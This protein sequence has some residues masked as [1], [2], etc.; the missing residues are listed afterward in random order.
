MGY[1][2]ATDGKQRL[3][4][5]SGKSPAAGRGIVVS[6]SCNA[7]QDRESHE[8]VTRSIIA[9]KLAALQ[10]YRYAGDG[11]DLA[12]THGEYIYFVPAETLMREQARAAGIR[13]ERDVYGGVVP[14][15]FVA[16]KAITHP[17]MNAR[18]CA[19]MGWTHEFSKTVEGAV[20]PGYSAFSREDARAAGA[21]LLHRGAVR[22]KPVRATGGRGQVVVAKSD[23]LASALDALDGEEIAC[24]GVALEQ[25]LS[26]VKTYSVGRVRVGD[27]V[28]TYVGT[29]KLTPDHAGLEVYGGSALTVVR[30]EFEV[31]LGLELD[32]AARLAVKQAR[33]YDAAARHCFPGFFASR[34]NY[35]VV[36]GRDMDGALHSGVL[37]QSWRIG[38]A[39]SAEIAALEAFRSEPT[40]NA[41]YAECTETYDE[42]AVP[43]PDATIYFRGVD[44]AVGF[45]MKYSIVSPHVHARP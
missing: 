3:A 27:L 45:L 37:E 7:A 43:P 20:L 42:L 33:A 22:V 28:A 5:P 30:G 26:D 13:S 6:C 40:L 39:S 4:G 1:A 8:Y 15:P 44:P 10:G 41:A 35:D 23:A 11:D 18:A 9:A 34:C 12:R 19:P 31:L 14:F 29:Q 16:T 25:D 2:S 24:Y 32:K 38:G 36:Q 21:L 17:L